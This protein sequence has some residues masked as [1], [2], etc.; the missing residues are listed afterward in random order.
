[1]HGFHLPL[2]IF[3]ASCEGQVCV[4]VFAVIVVYFLCLIDLIYL[5]Y[6][7]DRDNN[8]GEKYE[9]SKPKHL[10]NRAY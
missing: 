2:I 7:I 3:Q 10:S 1:M 8:E 4:I 6:Y 9:K 5:V